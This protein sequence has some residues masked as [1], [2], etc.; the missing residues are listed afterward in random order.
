MISY[1]FLKA[2]KKITSRYVDKLTNSFQRTC[3]PPDIP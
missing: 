3:T 1:T 2:D